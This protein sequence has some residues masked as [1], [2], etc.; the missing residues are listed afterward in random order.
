MFQK[1]IVKYWGLFHLPYCGWYLDYLSDCNTTSERTKRKKFDPKYLEKLA[2]SQS[3]KKEDINKRRNKK[4][5]VY[6]FGT[7]GP[8]QTLANI[9]NS[10]HDVSLDLSEIQEF[11]SSTVR[12]KTLL[13]F[14]GV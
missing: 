5:D 7:L 4:R 12:K 11:L 1:E 8:I 2:S 10:N 14:T 6:F 13:K 3:N 9:E